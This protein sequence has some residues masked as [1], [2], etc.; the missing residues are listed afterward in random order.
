MKTSNS[1]LLYCPKYGIF[2]ENIK[3]SMHQY[4]PIEIIPINKS[5]F[6]IFSFIEFVDALSNK[7]TCSYSSN[8]SS[9]L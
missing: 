1:Q 7:Y 8:N 2:N 3:S 4:S 5:Q 6:D 9:S